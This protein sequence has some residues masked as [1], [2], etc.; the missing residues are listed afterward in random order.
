MNIN[1]RGFVFLPLAII[2]FILVLLTGLYFS[3]KYVYDLYHLTN[4]SKTTTNQPETEE[5]VIPS[6]W[7]TFTSERLGFTIKFPPRIDKDNTKIEA[8]DMVKFYATSKSEFPYLQLAIKGNKEGKGAIEW[9]QDESAISSLLKQDLYKNI[10]WE[11]IGDWYISSNSIATFGAE[12]Y[13]YGFF[14][15]NRIVNVSTTQDR[16]TL[17]KITKT[18]KF[19]KVSS[20][21]TYK[22]E[23]GLYE[24]KYPLYFDGF[25]RHKANTTELGLIEDLTLTNSD[26]DILHFDLRVKKT[27]QTMDDYYQSYKNQSPENVVVSEKK[28]LTTVNGITSL[29]FYHNAPCCGDTGQAEIVFNHNDYLFIL[30]PNDFGM[31]LEDFEEFKKLMYEIISTFRFTK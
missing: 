12:N 6:D 11:Q 4:I 27:D 13:A 3:N 17:I 18:F 28:E 14:D 29:Y 2:I 19:T 1:S 20:W 21:T 7:E 9:I 24:F 23:T 25:Q 15:N 26:W 22:S 8:F 16:A 31:D 30:S 5:I 10:A